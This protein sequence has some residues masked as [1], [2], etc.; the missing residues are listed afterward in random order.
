[1]HWLAPLPVG[2]PLI[3][4]AAIAATSFLGRRVADWLALLTAVA[5]AGLS[6]AIFVHVGSGHDVYWFSGWKPVHGIALGVSFTVDRFGAGM[7]VL[8]AVLMVAALTFAWHFFDQTVEHRF[9]ILM[10]VFLAAMVGFSLS[11]DL[12]N[13]FVFFELM[14]VAA[15]A[16]TGYK[17]ET[18]APLQ[19]ALN[20]AISNSVAGYLILLGI[21]L[22]YAHTG[23]LNLAQLGHTIGAHHPD[24]L[25]VVAF[26]LLT[27]G[28]MVKA[29]IVPFHFWLADAHAVA[30]TP[31]CVL[32]SGAMV[33]LGLY[34][35]ARIY[36]TVFAGSFG[37]HSHA[38][39]HVLIG[40]GVLTAIV[41]AVMCFLQQHIKRLLAFST[42]SHMGLFLIGFGL[43]DHSAL[44]GVAIYVLAHGAVKGAL[45]I[46]T[47]IV[48]HRIRGV[49]EEA[50]RGAGRVIPWTGVLF[51]IGGL[52]L[53]DLPPFGTGLGAELIESSASKAANYHWMPWLFGLTAAVTGGAVLRVAGR[54]FLG[55][56]P[57]ELDRFPAD[58]FGELEDE[59]ETAEARERTP[60]TMFI[61]AV[62]LLAAGLALGLVPG[63]ATDAQHAAA[64]FQDQRGYATAVLDGKE[65]PAATGESEHPTLTGRAYGVISTAAAVGLAALA[66]FR[67]RL[68][69][70]LRAIGRAL[71]IRP[72]FIAVRRLH[73][74]HIGD[75]IAWLTLGIAGVGGL[76]S[77]ALR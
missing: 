59:T 1:M 23:A 57:R 25:V 2:I 14:G 15:Y 50:R 42:V 32:F 33:E 72:A 9:P 54:V 40:L 74:G 36:W 56:G 70:W 71:D 10:L 18:R 64:H 65:I 69:A 47:G 75:Y 34:G 62:L 27:V 38:L 12:F 13:M 76:F 20:F 58:R 21:G 24:G 8:V 16:L 49:D 46:C 17:V 30:P 29:A 22:V 68:P 67:K 41:G 66:L 53:A 77:L 6:I 55:W 43:L 28:F 73:S 35:I 60:K 37:P 48:L 61:P 45:F 5:V 4:A 11:G 52:A 7:A 26:T 39:S 31:V 51:A 19:G 63:L 3:V 44:G